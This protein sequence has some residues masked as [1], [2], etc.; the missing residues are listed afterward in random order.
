M[1]L[2]VPTKSGLPPAE[3]NF[4]HFLVADPL[5]DATDAYLKLGSTDNKN[6]AQIGGKRYLKKPEV[7]AYVG[8]LMAE[9]EK[10]LEMDEDWVMSRLRD[11]HDRCMQSEPVFGVG[12]KRQDENGNDE[13]VPI[14]YKFDAG[15]ATKS[16]E[17]IGKHLKM[18]SDKIDASQMNVSMNID[19]GSGKPVI[20]GEFKRVGS[21]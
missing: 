7:R 2:V 1:Q 12:S 17:L 11:I 6:S 15:G 20:E 16:L 3:H 5:Q 13:F 14:Y 10:R 21:G 9:R 4:C 19:L 8:L 18:F